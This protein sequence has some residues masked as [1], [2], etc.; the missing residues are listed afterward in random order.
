MFFSL[1]NKP[2]LPKI[3]KFVPYGIKFVSKNILAKAYTKPINLVGSIK[4]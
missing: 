4:H 3:S 2:K 1:L